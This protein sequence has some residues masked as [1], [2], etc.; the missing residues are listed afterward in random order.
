LSSLRKNFLA[1]LLADALRYVSLYPHSPTALAVENLFPR[2]Q[3]A[4]YRERGIKPRRATHATRMALMVLARWLDWR[5]ALV[6]VQPATLLRWRR[7]GF[8]RFWRWTPR[9]GRPPIPA[10]IRSS[11]GISTSVCAISG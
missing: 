5:Q 4:L 3:L 10:G 2:K 11:H 8:R 9:H 1:T 7:E 6:T